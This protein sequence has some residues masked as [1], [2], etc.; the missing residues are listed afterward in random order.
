M[1]SVELIPLQISFPSIAVLISNGV[2]PRPQG[3]DRVRGETGVS[4]A[5]SSE[6][7][8]TGNHGPELSRK[9]EDHRTSL[10]FSLNIN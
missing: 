1:D 3:E 5:N 4:E 8:R 7:N 9:V 2:S 6:I 10:S